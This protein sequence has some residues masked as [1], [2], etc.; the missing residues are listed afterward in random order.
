MHAGDIGI[1]DLEYMAEASKTVPSY[2]RNLLGLCPIGWTKRAVGGSE[3]FETLSTWRRAS[4]TG[5]WTEF[6]LHD[7]IDNQLQSA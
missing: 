7:Q 3:R 2:T 4:G 5:Q 6:F 1:H